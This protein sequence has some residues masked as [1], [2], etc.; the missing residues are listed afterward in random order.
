MLFAPFVSSTYVFVYILYSQVATNAFGGRL[1]PY[2]IANVHMSIDLGEPDAIN[3][4]VWAWTKF[5]DPV[6][7][8]QM[9]KQPPPACA[10]AVSASIRRLYSSEF[11]FLPLNICK[12]GRW[13]MGFT[14]EGGG[15]MSWWIRPAGAG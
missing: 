13:G 9:A 14:G 11:T 6:E 4:G 3:C 8:A 5:R 10:L 2:Q 12:E 15:M 1:F 7:L